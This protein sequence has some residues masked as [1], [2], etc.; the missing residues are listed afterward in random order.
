MQKM[1]SVQSINEFYVFLQGQFSFCRRCLIES[2]SI[3]LRHFQSC[4]GKRYPKE[5][6]G[7]I[8]S[9]NV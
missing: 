8:F 4:G 6:L 3:T 9:K 5:I 2:G 7:P 1:S